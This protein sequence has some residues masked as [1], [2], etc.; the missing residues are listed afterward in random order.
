ML[1]IQALAVGFLRVQTL[2]PRPS[3]LQTPFIEDSTWVVV[4]I[5]IP[6][7]APFLK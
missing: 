1:T 5:R 4:E 3:R 7:W 6:F 2:S